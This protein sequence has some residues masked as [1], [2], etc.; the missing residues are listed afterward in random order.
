MGRCLYR[1]LPE[2]G[3]DR[4]PA[5]SGDGRFMLAADLR[6]DNRDELI[7]SLAIGTSDGS[8]LSDSAL[9]LRGCLAWGRG[10]LTRMTGDFAFA[11]WDGREHSLLLARDT[12]GERPL[13]YRQA[14][15][16]F[17]YAT[18]ASPLARLPGTRFDVDEE[19]LA[20]FVADLPDGGRRSFFEGVGALEPGHCALVTRGRIAVERYWEP[21]RRPLHFAR[22]EDYGEALREQLDAAVA[23]RLRRSHGRVGSQLSSGLDSSA[24]TAS[25]ALALAST[26]QRLLAFTSAPREGFDG[27]V[28]AGRIGDESPIAAETARLYPNIDHHIV[29]PAGLSALKLAEASQRLSGQP[30]GHVCNNVWWQGID[31]RAAEAGVSVMLTGEAGNFTISAGLGVD[32]L[33]DLAGSWRRWWSEARALQRRGE[34]SWPQMLNASFGSRLPESLYARLRGRRPQSPLFVAAAWRERMR[35]QLESAG[36]ET[37]PPIDSAARRWKFLRMADPGNFRKR[38]LAE[39]GVEERDPTNDRRLVEF[40]FSLPSEALLDKGERRPALRR[41]L[42]GRLP[43][44]VLDQRLR[45]QQMPDWYEQI[46]SDE[47]R[48]FARAQAES[49]LAASVVDLDAVNEAAQSWPASGWEERP[50]I[51]MYRMHLLRSLAAASFISSARS[52]GLG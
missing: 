24:V 50:I 44:A 3:F 27:P 6:I 40:C 1:L 15:G 16:F 11:L 2:D 37:R 49:G 10:I 18:M 20:A 28:V 22:R 38:S 33:G 8:S 45:G 36:W 13:H 32:T 47:V 30:V 35:R 42:E 52:G 14:G 7:S 31:R 12:A 46:R 19:R 23:R 48:A 29:R 41:A 4:Q 34:F 51:Y 43:G 21:S 5:T 9:L 39:W 25:A 17:A 26:G